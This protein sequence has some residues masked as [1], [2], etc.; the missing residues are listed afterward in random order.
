MTPERWEQIRNVLEKALELTPEQRSAFLDGACSS[1]PSLRK[2]VES[3]LADSAN[4]PSGFLQSS[5]M[6]EMISAELEGVGSVAA[7]EAGQEFA[8]RFQLI[9]KLGEGGMGQ[10]WLAEQTLPVQRQVA[11]KLIK[12]GMYDE[13]VARRFESE[14]Q[15]LAI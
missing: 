7:L 2:E 12:A 6:A 15:S 13:S 1:D 10:V 11:L 5:A 14:R 3:L 9:R 8:Q 4:V